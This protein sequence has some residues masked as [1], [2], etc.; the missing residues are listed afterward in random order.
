MPVNIFTTIDDPL[1]A[2]ASGTA[3]NGINDAGLVVGAY[4]DAT[5]E[6][7]FL[8]SSGGSFTTI[9]VSFGGPSSA[10]EALG[11]NTA[12]T[13]VGLSGTP[14]ATTASCVSAAASRPASMVPQGAR[15][16]S[17]AVSTT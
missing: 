2:G 17:C 4:F 15:T 11:I 16:P 1:A 3:A 5:G 8:R 6:H 7:G 10:T 12:G 14:R 9:D 13:V